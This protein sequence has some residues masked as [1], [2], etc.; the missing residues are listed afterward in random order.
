[1]S[2]L[3]TA[4]LA[5]G[6]AHGPQ[7]GLVEL[8]FAT[9]ADCAEK[10]RC[11]DVDAALVPTIELAR[12]P[13]LAVVPRGCI[14]CD[15]AVRSILLVCK[16]QFDDVESIAIDQGS[17]TSVVLAQIL[18]LELHGTR[19]A[20]RPHAPQLDQMLQAADA[21]LIIGDP[22]LRLDP[23]MLEWR[24]QPVHVYDLGAEWKALT[25]LPMVFAVWAANPMDDPAPLVAALTGSA[26]YGLGRIEEIVLAESSR[27][28]FEADFL[29]KYLTHDIR[30]ELAA[31]ER[32][33]MDTYLRM[34]T[35]QGLV[36]APR[37]I[38]YLSDFEPA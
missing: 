5:W 9:P 19:P 15:G 25:G 23:K 29:R 20:V 2:Y 21:A 36:K 26:A 30:Y 12:Q 14:A 34:A 35:R 38:G 1:M 11:G 16:K 6:L 8:E 28:G 22:A 4:P 32:E 31:A 13:D 17:R 37:A 18:A 33:A 7:R 3:N 24:G 10:L 27:L